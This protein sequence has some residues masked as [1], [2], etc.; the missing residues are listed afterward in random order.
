MELTRPFSGI[1]A[2]FLPVGK[3]PVG[4]CEFASDVCLSC[5]A[6]FGGQNVLGVDCK[7]HALRFLMNSESVEITSK[8]RSEATAVYW[9]ASGDC[10]SS[11]GEKLAEV[12]LLLSDLGINQNGFTR[13]VSFWNKVRHFSNIV[14]TI[15]APKKSDGVGFLM[16]VPNYETGAVSVYFDRS[17]VME[18]FG[19]CTYRCDQCI[20]EKKGCFTEKLTSLPKED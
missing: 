7:E 11:L 12:I 18:C 14:L 15:E 19:D 6:S 4:T 17:L 5:C 9:F 1:R 3:P 16:A 10:P 8:I 13:N 20:E 2:I